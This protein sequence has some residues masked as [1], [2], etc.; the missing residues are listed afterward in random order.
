M[1]DFD[2]KT[3]RNEEFETL[4]DNMIARERPAS[5]VAR[6]EDEFVKR[7]RMA[8]RAAYTKGG[9]LEHSDLEV[10]LDDSVLRLPK[11]I[12]GASGGS[13]SVRVFVTPEEIEAE[14]A[15]MEA[16]DAEDDE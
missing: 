8:M 15:Q 3:I 16:D 10:E 7:K 11:V 14:R 1:P 6:V 13:V 9:K 2:V 4:I 5:A 12:F